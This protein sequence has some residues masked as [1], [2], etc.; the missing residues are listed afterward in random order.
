[1]ISDEVPYTLV[2][3]LAEAGAL[4][5]HHMGLGAVHEAI[6]AAVE[7]SD[8]AEEGESHVLECAFLVGFGEGVSRKAFQDWGPAE[9]LADIQAALE[10]ARPG[11]IR[12]VA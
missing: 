8:H 1:M 4:I 12:E 3:R 10:R 9:P 2:H 6:E 5:G 7:Y 11:P